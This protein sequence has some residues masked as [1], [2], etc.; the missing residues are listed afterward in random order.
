[1]ARPERIND[2]MILLELDM[3][4]NKESDELKRYIMSLEEKI[5]FME[6]NLEDD[7]K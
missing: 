7:G 4:S 3:L 5:S 1:M 6:S 2:L